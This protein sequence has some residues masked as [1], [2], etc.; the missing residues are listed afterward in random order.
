MYLHL[1]GNWK[2]CV[3]IAPQIDCLWRL[4]AAWAEEAGRAAGQQAESA[5]TMLLCE[6]LIPLGRAYAAAQRWNAEQGGDT[7][8]GWSAA[9]RRNAEQGWLAAPAGAALSKPQA[10]EELLRL[11]RAALLSDGGGEPSGLYVTAAKPR[12]GGY[13]AA[14][15]PAAAELAREA[16]AAAAALQGR[17]LL[18]SE[19]RALLGAA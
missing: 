9:K 11:A 19:A 15:R 2:A 17:A 10:A 18:R 13:A 1:S 3:S 12:H 14:A 5:A 16:C 4:D 6:A 8:Q 7:G